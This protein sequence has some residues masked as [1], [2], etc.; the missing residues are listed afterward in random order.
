[1]LDLGDTRPRRR[2]SLTPMID[3]VFLLL[4]FFMLAARFGLDMQLPLQVAGQGEGYSG[5]PR[6]V[7]VTPEGLRLNGVAQ[8]EA[9]LLAELERL[10]ET[11]EDAIVLR[12]RDEATL[13]RTVEVMEMLGRGG[14]GRVVLME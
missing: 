6:L 14:F 9:G 7:E 1:M 8:D 12:P 4:V 10:T 13:Q 5:P 11:P 2:P 3:V